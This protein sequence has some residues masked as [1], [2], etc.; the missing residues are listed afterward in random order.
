MKRFL[1]ISAL[2]LF[3]LTSAAA[4]STS[5][6][7]DKL[8]SPYEKIRLALTEDSLEGVAEEAIAIRDTANASDPEAA[9]AGELLP[10]IAELAGNLAVASELATAREAFSELSKV[11]V[12]Y[13]SKVEGERP[14]VLY[15]AMATQSW[16][17]PAGEV[18]NP[19]YGQSMPNCGEVV[20]E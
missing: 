16:L 15:C 3:A 13:R 2:V 12:R 11:L 10:D 20:E 9:E 17:Q 14:A 8:I 4:A 1:L 18:G 6:V 19:Y 7:F 5:P